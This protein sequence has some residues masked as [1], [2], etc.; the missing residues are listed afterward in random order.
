MKRLNKTESPISV[1][2]YILCFQRQP[3]S[4]LFEFD[5]RVRGLKQIDTLSGEGTFNIVSEK[6]LL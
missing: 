3:A 1:L 4:C 5:I 2:L 6:G